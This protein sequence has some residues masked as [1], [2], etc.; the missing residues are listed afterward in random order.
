MDW[1]GCPKI[2]GI[3]VRNGLEWVSENY[4][5]RCPDSSEYAVD[6]FRNKIIDISNE[7]MAT[8]LIARSQFDEGI[9]S[10]REL[11]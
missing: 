11:L 9:R 1:S 8:I 3:G 2:I 4:W 7:M 10:Q 5:N 6:S